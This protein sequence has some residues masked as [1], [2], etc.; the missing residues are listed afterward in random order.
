MKT[1]IV[2]YMG[3]TGE[4]LQAEVQSHEV[5]LDEGEATFYV[6]DELVAYF[7]KVI[8]VQLKA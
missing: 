1:Y 5:V 2:T 7:T 6:N 4:G 8:A 3:A